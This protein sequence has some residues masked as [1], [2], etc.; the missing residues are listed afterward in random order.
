MT[1][2][3]GS[4]AFSLVTDSP[5]NDVDVAGSP[6]LRLLAYEA[7]QQ[8][9]VLDLW[10][11]LERHLTEVPLA[12]SADWTQTWLEQYGDVVRPWF[13]VGLV[14]QEV[15]GICLLSESRRQ[16]CGPF[17]VRSL[18]IG[19]AGEP[20]GSSVCVEYN[21]VLV[22]PDYRVA[23]LTALQQWIASEQWDQ[24]QWDGFSET[25]LASWPEWRQSRF[26]SLADSV[27]QPVTEFRPET[28]LTVRDRLR[29]SR[30]FDL[31]QLRAAGGEILASLGKSTRSNLKRRLNQIGPI[32]LEWAETLPQAEEIFAELV[33]LHQ[34]R[35]NAVGQP[36]AFASSRFFS[37]Q[38]RLIQRLF[39]E[40]RVVLVRVKTPTATVG[41]LYLLVDRNRLLDYVSGFISFEDFPSPGLISHYL[42]ME[43]ALERG[44]SA[45]DFLV[46]DKRHKENLGKSSQQLQW[47]VCERPRWKYRW[48]N[49]LQ[50]CRQITKRMVTPVINRIRAM[51]PSR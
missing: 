7:H 1:V 16:H 37:F 48:R 8:A 23:F 28:R 42:C 26:S 15:Q 2:V 4:H 30:Y 29:E 40:K 20:Y 50:S 21:D 27:L 24:C 45:Y 44:Y 41:C 9:V 10:R 49:C 14:G 18:H 46:G 12:C 47:R 33:Q 38:Q 32:E 31:E 36:G 39:P 3:S 11:Q 43:A 5:A 25:A 35:W 17:P 51:R 22:Q 6:G 13:V 34:A 19:T